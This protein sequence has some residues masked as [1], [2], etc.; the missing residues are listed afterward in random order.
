MGE[1]HTFPWCCR[2]IAISRDLWRMTAASKDS[3]PLVAWL[4]ILAVQ[5]PYPVV[6]LEL[7]RREAKVTDF[8][9]HPNRLPSRRFKTFDIY[10]LWYYSD[11]DIP[12]V[13]DDDEIFVFPELLFWRSFFACWADG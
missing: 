1:E 9:V 13:A 7:R 3:D 4:A 5:N 12:I 2:H 6:Y 11:A 10:P 8:D